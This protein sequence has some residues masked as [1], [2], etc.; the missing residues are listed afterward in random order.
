MTTPA[1]L[2][3][4]QLAQF[5]EEGYLVVRGLFDL[6]ED[7]QPVVAEYSALLDHL[8]KT[9]VAEGKLSS[10]YDDLPFGKRLTRIIAESGQAYYQH[11][12]ISLPQANVSEET[13][14]HHGP[15][16]F[17]LMC[18]PRLLDAVE[19]FIGSEIYSNPVQHVRIKPP[20]RALP[21]DFARNPLVTQTPWHQDLGVIDTEADE[22]NILTVWFPITE[23]TVENGCLAVVPGSHRQDLAL[24][25]PHPTGTVNIPEKMIGAAGVPL[26]MNPGD[27]LFMTSTTMHT[28]LLN[29][30]DKIRWSFDL[31]YNP[32]GQKTGRPWFPGFIARSRSHPESELRDAG[33]WA[34]LWRDARSHLARNG[35]PTFNRWDGN[36]EGCA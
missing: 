24:H 6:E 13:P 20:E 7:I 17:N 23:A 18:S 12:D 14:I 9:W 15:A 22:S 16:I 5:E 28:S 3:A 33:Q 29:V 21:E 36:A 32:I 25:C 27:V 31:R 35:D 4:V 10:A 30:S 11:M 34:A 19:Q 1:I 2:S 26:P 8:A